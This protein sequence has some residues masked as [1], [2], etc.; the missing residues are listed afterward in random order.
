MGGVVVFCEGAGTA[1][2]TTSSLVTAASM[3]PGQPVVFAECDSSGGD[4]AAWADLRETPGWAT[5]VAGGD[6]SWNG[7]RTHF[8]EMPSGLS[9]LCAPTQTRTARPVVR[10]SAARFGS[11]LGSMSD[12][13]TVA[14]CG[15]VG[16]D[17][18]GWLGGA[19][20]V[21]LLVRQAPSSTGATVSE[22]IG[23][24]N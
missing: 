7:L 12:V 21:L 16:S 5:A 20:V 22:S 17:L 10:E 8:Q 14:D 4:L 24:R 13:V 19:A 1:T 9:V 23:R 6:R 18:P 11:L 3:P 15:R 2:S